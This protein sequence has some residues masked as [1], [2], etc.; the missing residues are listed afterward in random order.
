M[1][2]LKNPFKQSW[3]TLIVMFLGGALLFGGFCGDKNAAEYKRKMAEWKKSVEVQLAINDSLR[4]RVQQV[5]EE[6]DERLRIGENQNK[7]INELQGSVK[8][9]RHDNDH[10]RDSLQTTLPDTCAPAL[11]LANKY[12]F[13]A[14][15][16]QLAVN[17]AKSL[18]STR[19]TDI[20]K[21]RHTITDLKFQNDSLQRIILKVPEYKP[22]KILGFIP[23]PDRKTTF[24]IGIVTGAL[25][26]RSIAK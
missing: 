4:K 12:R 14:D 20:L 8:K 13:E 9:M 3:L 1:N 10:L 21:L 11:D 22:S 18:D 2:Q 17:V 23:M 15:S 6:S 16:L 5:E 26:V 24:V 25:L 19:V 7:R